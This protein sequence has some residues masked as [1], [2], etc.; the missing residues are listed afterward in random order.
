MEN[1]RQHTR[2]KGDSLNCVLMELD[3]SLNLPRYCGQSEKL[4]QKQTEDSH[5]IE[6]KDVHPRVQD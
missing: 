2:V 5:G 4:L 6:K 1:K 3:G